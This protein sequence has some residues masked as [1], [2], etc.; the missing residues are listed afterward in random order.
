MATRLTDLVPDQQP[1]KLA[2]GFQFTE[3]PVWHRDGYLLFSDVRANTIYKYTLDGRVEPH[4]KPSRN[5]NGL[6]Y[7]RQGNLIACEH[8]GRR[9]SRQAPDGR[10]GPVASHWNGKR[11]NSPNDVV[12]HSSNCI[13][14][15]DPPY[16][17]TPDQA[18]LGFNGLYRIDTD[19]NVHLLCSDFGRPNGLAFSPD[20]SVLYVDDTERRNVRAFD[21]KADL[22]VT[23]DRLFIDMDVPEE[24]SPDGM[25]VDIEGNL[26]VT[27]GGGVWVVTPEA[28]HLGTLVFPEQPANLAFGG[29]DYRTLFA[30]ARTGLYSLRVHV[31]G[32]R[33]FQGD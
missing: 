19:G 1:T 32:I 17:I 21:A 20:E 10:M 16:G 7:D 3:G 9:V 15:T 26:Y 27:G 6:T 5:S 8:S 18:E 23:N 33:L 13:F 29:P 2:G 12:V 31:P 30:T 28:E 14:F 4:L 24:G 11:F 22:T 25:K